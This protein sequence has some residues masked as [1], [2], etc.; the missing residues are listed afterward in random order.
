MKHQNKILVKEYEI[1]D[2]ILKEICLNLGCSKFDFVMDIKRY[3]SFRR[4]I[5]YFLKKKREM[6][7]NKSGD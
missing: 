5:E 6:I 3:E 2:L 4:R 7:K 1:W